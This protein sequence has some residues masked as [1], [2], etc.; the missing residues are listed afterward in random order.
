MSPSSLSCRFAGV[1]DMTSLKNFITSFAA[2]I[3]AEA[4]R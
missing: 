3:A 1:S 2:H 4:A